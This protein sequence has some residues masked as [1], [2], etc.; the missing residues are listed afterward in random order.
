MLLRQY[1]CGFFQAAR[2]IIITQPFPKF[3]KSFV[4]NFRQ[5]KDCGAGVQKAQII[6]RHGFD[7]GLLQ[8]DF[9]QPD[10]IGRPILT[11]GQRPSAFGIP[12]QNKLRRLS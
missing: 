9:R 2:P 12:L 8:H 5:I 3:E 6:G 11:P 4:V 7:T 10:P 1:H